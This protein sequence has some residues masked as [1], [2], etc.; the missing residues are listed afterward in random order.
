MVTG[1]LTDGT[2]YATTFV[3]EYA[4]DLADELKRPAS[5]RG[6]PPEAQRAPRH[7]SSP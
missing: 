2:T 3:A 5:D 6:R 1:E 7:A 4:D